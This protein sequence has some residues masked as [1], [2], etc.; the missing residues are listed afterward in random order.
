MP[1]TYNL[2]RRQVRSTV[3]STLTSIFLT[4][5]DMNVSLTDNR[6]PHTAV[7]VVATV[8]T[9]VVLSILSFRFR[10]SL[11]RAIAGSAEE[12]SSTAHEIVD[13]TASKGLLVLVAITAVVTVVALRR[14]RAD[15]LL[16]VSAGV[17]TIAAYAGGEM[18]KLLVTEE[19]PCRAIG[20]ET[21]TAC[22]EAGDWSWPSNHA[23]IAAAF[24]TAC[25]MVVRR[26]WPYVAAAAALIA[27]SRVAAGVHY[28]H[29]ILS[30]ITLGI[31]VTAAFGLLVNAGLRRVFPPSVGSAALSRRRQR[32]TTTS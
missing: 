23:T 20:I 31:I 24:A 8:A 17:G 32:D 4:W 2:G 18:I 19:R 9:L 25:V 14:G 3:R 27:V 13:A 6:H 15:F 30:G 29:D 21:V 28:V 5:L 26:L 22:P 12:S 10:D 7:A 11:Y 16:I 1:A